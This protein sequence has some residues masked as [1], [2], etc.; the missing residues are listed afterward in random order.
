MYD[1]RILLIVHVIIKYIKNVVSTLARSVCISRPWR[2][3]KE[4]NAWYRTNFL[5]VFIIMC[6]SLHVYSP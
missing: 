1:T 6:I 5:N 4:L 2:A 3:F